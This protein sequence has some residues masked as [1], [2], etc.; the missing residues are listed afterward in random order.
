VDTTRLAAVANWPADAPPVE[1]VADALRPVA[2]PP[3]RIPSQDLTLD[4]TTSGDVR[5]ALRL[6][7]A[8]SS[9]TGLGETT[10]Q[11]GGLRDG[12]YTYQQRV[13]VCRDGCRLKGIQL[14]TPPG[15]TTVSG[16]VT[17]TGLRVVNP[18]RP[19]LTGAQLAEVARWRVSD[20]T[21]SAAPEGL[22]LD[23][24][25]PGGLPEGAWIQPA[26][27]PDPLPVAVAGQSGVDELTGFDNRPV[28]VR[29]VATLPAV[30]RLGT[31][32][33]L[34]DLEYLDRRSVDSGLAVQPQVWLSAG[35]PADFERRLTERGVP[36]IGD[37]T[38]AQLDRQL[39]QQGP[40][41]ALWFYVLAG[42]LAVTLAAGALLLAAVVDRPRRV[43]DLSA[44]RAQGLDRRALSRATLWTYPLLVLA[45]VLT[46][47]V[48]A[49]V[50]W[51]LTG[52]ALPLAGLDPPDLPLPKW[53]RAPILLVAG[54]IQL[55]V[56]A[57]VA[58]AAGGRTHREI[59]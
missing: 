5:R 18:A 52:W 19:V 35:A 43:E 2:T 13:D 57:G 47:L 14:A 24:D 31:T 7:V 39:D 26:D 37:V 46:G 55:V 8:L 17:I 4:V 16:R 9:L 1:S 12:A 59:S 49:A 27:T 42:V 48:I 56:L 36:V 23:I 45:S 51:A 29:A 34:A 10:V 54:T 53:P 41:L 11:L 6:N 22:R 40:A 20:A 32:A 58:Y 33:T 50:L 28:R 15:V 3:I 21:A 25:A 44:L 38:V 30:P